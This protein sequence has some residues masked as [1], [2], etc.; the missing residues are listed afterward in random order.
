[1]TPAEIAAIMCRDHRDR[2]LCVDDDSFHMGGK[3]WGALALMMR[4][5]S[6]PGWRCRS[7]D[8]FL[9]RTPSRLA[10]SSRAERDG[11]RPDMTGTAAATLDLVT[12]RHAAGVPGRARRTAA[13]CCPTV[14]CRT[15]REAERALRTTARRWCCARRP[16]SATV[17]AYL[18]RCLGDTSPSCPPRRAASR[19]RA[20]VRRPAPG[21]RAERADRP[22]SATSSRSR[23]RR[24]GPAPRRQPAGRRIHPTRRCCWP[25]RARPAA[26]AVRLSYSGLAGN[27]AP[28][29]GL[30]ASL[31]R[32][33]PDD[34]ADQAR[35][36]LSVLNSHLLAGAC[37]ILGE[38]SPLSP[39]RGTA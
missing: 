17:L 6:S 39:R 13:P 22:S 19:I 36:R 28:S 14:I 26:Q 31:G 33:R 16:R 27:T 18:P 20:R 29:S 32:T 3:S 8:V 35:L 11:E 21:R 4:R 15:G 12:R 37:V 24:D 5:A 23:S 30:W 34:P 25:P 10:P 38:G 1:M 7:L 2:R 9:A